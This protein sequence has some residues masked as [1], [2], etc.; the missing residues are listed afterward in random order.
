MKGKNTNI[1]GT[2]SSFFIFNVGVVQY[3]LF[4][5]PLAL[6]AVIYTLKFVSTEKLFFTF[7]WN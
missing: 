1:T 5:I 4:D 3:K 2:V 7:S 6:V